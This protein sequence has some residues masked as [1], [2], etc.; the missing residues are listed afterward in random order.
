MVSGFAE[1]FFADKAY[2][3]T[4]HGGEQFRACFKFKQMLS[5]KT[6]VWIPLEVFDQHL[7][8]AAT[9]GWSKYTT[10]HTYYS[11][12]LSCFSADNYS[13]LLML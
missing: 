9:K 1:F 7:E 4:G 6:Q 13:V 2:F 11:D 5:P 12:H 8:C 10:N 3:K